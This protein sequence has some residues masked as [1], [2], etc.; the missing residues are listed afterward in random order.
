M[1]IKI[2]ANFPANLD[3]KSLGRFLNVG[4]LL[5]EQGHDVEM[6]TSTFE[7]GLKRHGRKVTGNFKTKITL[8][9]EPGY[10][11]NISIKRLYSH[12]KWGKKVAKYIKSH[13]SPDVVYLA[14]PS[15]TAGVEMA[16]YC[17]RNGVKFVIDVQDLWPE[18]FCMVVR[19]KLLRL[20]FKPMEWYVNKVY[21]SADRVIAVSETYVQRA[22]RVNKKDHNGLSIFLGNDGDLFDSS[23]NSLSVRHNDG[24]IR[25][26]YIGT[27]GYSYDIPCVLDALKIVKD[28]N[29]ELASRLMF[30]IMGDGPLRKRFED[31]ANSIGINNMVVFTGKLDYPNMVGKMCSC[32]IIINPIIKGSSASI[33]NKVGDYALSG[34]PVINTQECVEYRELVSKYN[35][36][37]NCE[38]GKA[39]DVADAI[40]KLSLDDEMRKTCGENHRMLGMEKFDRRNTYPQIIKYLLS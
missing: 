30:V 39:V 15:L 1:N 12:Y 21:K 19:N 16:K 31:R 22:L 18:A 8:L 37:I 38:A 27:L 36:G 17:R 23:K 40:I 3:G 34:L 2:V 7:H 25:I 10:P 5:C 32:D 13:Q 9:H 20:I 35:C 33:T 28:K 4:E 6:I 11:N 29:A 14:L 24:K 26:A